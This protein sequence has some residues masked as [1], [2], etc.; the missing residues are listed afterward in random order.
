MNLKSTAQ[1]SVSL[2]LLS[3]DVKM[4][5]QIFPKLEDVFGCSELKYV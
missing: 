4:A 1:N 5:R 2:C 3:D